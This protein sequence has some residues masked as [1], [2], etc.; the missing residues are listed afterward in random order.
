MTDAELVR[1]VCEGEKAAREEFVRRWSPRVLAV[2]RA[3]VQHAET[4]EDIAQET[5][6]RGLTRLNTLREP[7]KLGAW[8]RG[9]ALRAC[10]DW[11][12]EQSTSRAH[13]KELSRSGYPE[14]L[15]DDSRLL[16]P[17]QNEERKRLRNEIDQLAEELR[18][19]VLLY[20]YDGATYQ[21]IAEMIG[22]SRA[23]VNAR[24]AKARSQ[25]ARRL[26]VMAR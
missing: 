3:R 14:P 20:Y 13:L 1:R 26:A 9:I 22:V 15:T 2:C 21:E 18:E 17:E 5:L 6:L 8:L 16:A 7:E 19:V 12:S 10:L 25:L 11:I 24:L 23:T 4:A